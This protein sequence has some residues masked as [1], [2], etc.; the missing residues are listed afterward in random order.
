MGKCPFA[1]ESGDEQFCR[2]ENVPCSLLKE[3]GVEPERFEECP[4][5]RYVQLLSEMSESSGG[6]RR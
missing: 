4:I 1:E 5:F 3:F 2:I 6:E